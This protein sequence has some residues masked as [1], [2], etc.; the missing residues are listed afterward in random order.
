MPNVGLRGAPDPSP[1]LTLESVPLSLYPWLFDASRPTH[2]VGLIYR[3]FNVL[4]QYLIYRIVSYRS[5]IDIEFSIY[6]DIGPTIFCLKSIGLED[7][8][9]TRPTTFYD[10]AL[11]VAW[12]SG[13]TL[14]FDRRAFAVLRST[15]S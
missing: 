4:F 15:N 14:V 12:L 8:K 3:I 11:M 6:H 13:R 5:I 7:I 10:N 1:S 9:Y 2:S